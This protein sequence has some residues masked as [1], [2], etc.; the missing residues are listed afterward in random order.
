MNGGW[1]MTLLYQHYNV[2]CTLD[3]AGKSERHASE[4]QILGQEIS[5]SLIW[6]WVKIRQNR[7]YSQQKSQK[8]IVT[9]KTNKF[10]TVS[11]PL[12]V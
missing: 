7:K 9:K 1:L 10:G 5:E 3:W 4:H 2:Q 6:V 12:V 11:Y 8:Q